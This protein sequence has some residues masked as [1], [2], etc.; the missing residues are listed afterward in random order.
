[1]DADSGWYDEENDTVILAVEVTAD[2]PHGV[3]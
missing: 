3:K 2:A 1:M